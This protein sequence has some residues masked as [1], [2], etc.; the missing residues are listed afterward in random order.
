[1]ADGMKW[2]LLCKQSNID[3]TGHDSSKASTSGCS[4]LLLEIRHVEKFVGP[5]D[6]ARHNKAL[7]YSYIKGV[8]SIRR[9]RWSNLTFEAMK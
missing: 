6:D 5:I 2:H 4:M 9:Y 7:R 8:W 3:D 1:M